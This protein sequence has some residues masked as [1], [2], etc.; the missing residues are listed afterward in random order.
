[1]LL[2]C[3]NKFVQLYKLSLC[4]EINIQPLWNIDNIAPLVVDIYQPSASRNIPTLGAIFIDV[5]R[6]RVDYL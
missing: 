1:M 6:G 4:N 2:W 5:P 3:S